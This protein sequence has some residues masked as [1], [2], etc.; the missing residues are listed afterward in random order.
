MGK[1]MMNRGILDDF[2]TTKKCLCEVSQLSKA[3]QRDVPLVLE[4]LKRLPEVLVCLVQEIT[5]SCLIQKWGL[6][7]FHQQKLYISYISIMGTSWEI[8]GI[9]LNKM[10]NSMPKTIPSVTINGWDFCHRSYWPLFRELTKLTAATEKRFVSS[11]SSHHDARLVTFF[12]WSKCQAPR[13]TD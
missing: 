1:M 4:L 12:L 6:W 7:G 2:G 11:I 3:G 5:R 8:T 9:Y 13:P 10:R